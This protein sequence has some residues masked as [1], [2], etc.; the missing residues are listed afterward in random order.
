M[1]ISKTFQHAVRALVFIQQKNL[2]GVDYVGIK[3]ISEGISSPTPITAKVLKDLVK[4]ELLI[5][6]KGPG[7]GFSISETTGSATVLDLLRLVEGPKILEKCLLGLPN[8]SDA[9]PCPAHFEYREIRSNITAL[10]ENL[11]ILE[12]S[13]NLDENQDLF[14]I[15]L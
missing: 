3:T 7:G 12:L 8:C 14:R 4:H 1:T 9:Q 6:R 13:K 10:F 2:N 11:N 5:S 15:G